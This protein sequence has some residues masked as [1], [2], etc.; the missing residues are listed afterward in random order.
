MSKPT[1]AQERALWLAYFI[2]GLAFPLI[3]WKVRTKKSKARH[4]EID[5]AHDITVE[6]SFP[7]SDPPSA[8]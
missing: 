7:A 3:L 6:D 4:D 8:W 2:V 5:E 1:A